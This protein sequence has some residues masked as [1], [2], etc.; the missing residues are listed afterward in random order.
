[1]T[2]MIHQIRTADRTR[3]RKLERLLRLQTT[4]VQ[5]RKQMLRDSQPS[6]V[7]DLEERSLDAEEQDVAFSLLER[8]CQTMQ[9]IAMALRR[10]EAGAFGTCSECR[11][12][13][14]GARLRALPFATLCLACQDGR[15]R[16]AAAAARPRSVLM[17]A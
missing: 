11:G 13:I 17:E 3:R 10:L 12:R 9:A 15:D 7:M 1:M 5:S 4:A 16:V 8:T 6:G 14:S 2:T